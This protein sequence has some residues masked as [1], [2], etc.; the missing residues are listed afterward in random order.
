MSFAKNIIIDKVKKYHFFIGFNFEIDGDY[1]Q[2]EDLEEMKWDDKPGSAVTT[3]ATSN[4]NVTNLTPLEGYAYYI[5][6]V[7]IDGFCGFQVLFKDY[8]HNAPRREATYFY[9]EDASRHKPMFIPHVIFNPDYPTYKLYNPTASSNTPR[10]F[11]YGEKWK[12]KKLSIRPDQITK[13]T[14]YMKGSMKG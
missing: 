1:Y 7:G 14:D 5:E 13:L 6:K 9:M 12:I 2:I 11:F 4:W 8:P 10:M 3:G